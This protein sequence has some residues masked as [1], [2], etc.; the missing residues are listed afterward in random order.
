MLPGVA[1]WVAS[2]FGPVA[3]TVFEVSHLSTVTG[4]RL[5]DGRVIVVKAR[6][7]VARARTCVA[8]QAALHED[9]FPCPAPL[10][11]VID[12]DGLAVHAEEYIS[13][14][15]YLVDTTA[16]DA[17]VLASLLA[18]LVARADRLALS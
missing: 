6:G 18:D 10:C 9:G 14:A 7:G 3:E 1:S 11:Q 4:I 5:C 16:A 8:G 17:D 15:P 12:I 13:A 2:T